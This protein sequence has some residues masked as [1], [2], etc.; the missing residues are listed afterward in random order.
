VCAWAMLWPR[1]LPCCAYA[2]TDAQLLGA[3]HRFTVYPYEPREE[4]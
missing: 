2:W 3:N 1:C 4:G